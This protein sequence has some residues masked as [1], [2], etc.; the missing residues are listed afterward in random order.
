MPV[1]QAWYETGVTTAPID[2]PAAV[3]VS[4]RLADALQYAL[5]VHGADY[6]KGTTIPYVSHLLG[7]ASLVLEHG[8][9]EDEVIAA[10]LHDT[11]EDGGGEA[12][13]AHLEVSFGRRVRDIV[14]ACSDSLV[15][16]PAEKEDWWERKVRYLCHLPDAPPDAL[17]VSAADKLHNLRSILTDFAAHGDALWE[18]FKAKDEGTIWYYRS[19]GLVYRRCDVPDALRR[20]LD[21]SVERLMS[22]VP[23]GLDLWESGRAKAM[24]CREAMNLP[25]VIAEW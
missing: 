12:R 16:N 23:A 6:R 3:P 20:E 10:L 24:R 1:T 19:L 15:A 22:D 14:G 25:R 21:V 13:L 8:G 18:R 2:H 4:A 5:T 17:L 7:V 11:A 9:R